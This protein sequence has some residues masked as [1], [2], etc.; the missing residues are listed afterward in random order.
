MTFAE[1]KTQ[2]TPEAVCLNRLGWAM[3]CMNAPKTVHKL[4]VQCG[5][6]GTDG[7]ADCCLGRACRYFDFPRSVSSSGN[8]HWLDSIVQLPL[9]AQKRL[10][11][12]HY[13][14]L[15]AT[16]RDRAHDFFRSGTEANLADINDNE[17]SDDDTLCRM[18][19]FLCWLWACEYLN[20]ETIFE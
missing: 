10:Y 6:D 9:A 19:A 18:S 5:I 4:T 8:I 20:G 7:E 2:T 1:A 17:L 15:S 13:G 11:L 14:T 3:D 16:G 12:G